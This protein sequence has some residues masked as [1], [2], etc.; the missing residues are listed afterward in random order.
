MIFKTLI[1]TIK[2]FQ[3][4]DTQTVESLYR[5]SVG[6]IVVLLLLVVGAIYYLYDSLPAVFTMYA[7]LFFLQ[8]QVRLLI[9]YSYFYNPKRY[10]LKTWYLLF[11][12]FSLS[13]ALG[14]LLLSTFLMFHVDAYYQLFVVTFLI[15]TASWSITSLSADIRLAVAY[16][17]I[18][19]PPLIVALMADNSLN[20]AVIAILL[21]FYIGHIVMIIKSYRHEVQYRDLQN[22]ELFFHNLFEEAPVGIFSYSQDLEILDCNQRFYTLL[23]SSKKNLIGLNITRLSDKRLVEIFR[24]TLEVGPQSY[25]GSYT[26]LKGN[27]FW[28]EIMTFPYSNRKKEIIGAVGIVEDK[29]KEHIA[30]Q[31]LNYLA[32]HDVLTGMFNRRGFSNYMKRFIQNSRHYHYYSMLFYLDLNQFKS[33]N[34]SLGHAIGDEVLLIISKRLKNILPE[35]CVISRLG[36]DEFLVII[37]YITMSKPILEKKIKEYIRLLNDIFN[38]P[39]SVRDLQ[40]R[41]QASIGIV[42]IKP[43]YTHIDEMVRQAD[44]TMYHAKRSTSHIAY[45]DESLDQRQREQFELQHDLTS[46]I[47]NH[48]FELFLQPIVDIEKDIPVAAEL[49]LRWRHPKRGIVSPSDFISLAHNAGLLIEITWYLIDRLFAY[50]AVWKQNGMWS[51]DYISINIDAQQLMEK[52]F[53]Q[54]FLAK[55]KAYHI[56]TKDIVIEITERSIIDN[57]TCAEA[58][59]DQLHDYG[60]R[61][62]IDDF[63]TGYSSLSYLKKLSFDILK[64]DKEF[65]DNIVSSPK[66]LAFIKDILDI[67][68]LFNYR[69]V[70]EGIEE[71]AQKELLRNN[72]SKVT[73]QGY[74]FSVPLE[75]EAFAMR[76]MKV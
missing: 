19:I 67:G 63:G 15:A 47:K 72:N 51:L 27:T 23:K 71:T 48:Q 21:F 7:I 65:V 30:L 38:N 73:Y 18:L 13:T 16:I 49:L 44:I 8:L 69:I 10:T 66:E 59:I 6:S 12:L 70:I 62:A 57:F 61:C 14:I 9:T 35:E 17:T 33:I 76:Y 26:S 24:K 58:V 41:I 22:R 32:E 42:T 29:T 53:V 54:N 36:G 75:I 40:L 34:D 1:R 60:I 4:I 68:K 43:G 39:F 3:S 64:I 20:I 11:V 45:Y 52:D 5:L 2:T 74:L 31:E 46:A 25:I 55:L 50:I 56:E 28:V 37:P